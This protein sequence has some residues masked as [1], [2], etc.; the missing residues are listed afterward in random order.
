MDDR[1]NFKSSESVWNNERLSQKEG[2]EEGEYIEAPIG[3]TSKKVSSR[4]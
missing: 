1:E 4:C 3:K 2:D